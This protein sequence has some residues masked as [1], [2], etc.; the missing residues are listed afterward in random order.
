LGRTLDEIKD[1]AGNAKAKSAW[2][3]SRQCDLADY[4]GSPNLVAA[5]QKSGHT[6]TGVKGFIWVRA[7][8][9]KAAPYYTQGG[10]YSASPAGLVQR[11]IGDGYYER[12]PVLSN[13]GIIIWITVYHEPH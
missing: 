12:V 6:V 2:I 11:Y 5:A 13:D 3:H 7:P 9:A 1:D 4:D 8:Q 10:Y